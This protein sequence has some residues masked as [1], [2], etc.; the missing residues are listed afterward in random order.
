MGRHH[1]LCSTTGTKSSF[2]VVWPCYVFLL[3]P[4]L[5]LLPLPLPLALPLPTF[6][7]LLPVCRP[8]MYCCCEGTQVAQLNRLSTCGSCSVPR[9]LNA[10]HTKGLR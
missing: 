2:L 7:L 3:M 9:Q 4:L 6:Q 1:R 8:L 10:S 5:A